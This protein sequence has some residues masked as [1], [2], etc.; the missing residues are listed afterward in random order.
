MGGL[1]TLMAGIA[2]EEAILWNRVWSFPQKIHLP[3]SIISGEIAAYEDVI[4]MSNIPSLRSLAVIYYD[5]QALRSLEQ[6]FVFKN[7]SSRSSI[8]RFPGRKVK[9]Y[10]YQA[11]TA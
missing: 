5:Q 6:N 4:E 1:A 10:G 7:I 11:E 3:S 2:L 9:L 8:P